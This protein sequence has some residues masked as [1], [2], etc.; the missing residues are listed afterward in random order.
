MLHGQLDFLNKLLRMLRNQAAVPNIAEH[1]V[2]KSIPG[3]LPF[4]NILC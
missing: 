1:F 4:L 3:I 2:G